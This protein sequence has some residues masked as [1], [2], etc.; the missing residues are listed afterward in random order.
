VSSPTSGITGYRFEVTKVGSSPL[1]VQ[2][3]D[4]TVQ[5]FNLTQ[6]PSFA[7]ASTYSIRVMLQKNGVWLNYY[8]TVCN[9][10]SPAVLSSTGATQ[11]TPS[12]CGITLPT[13]SSLIAT[14]SLPGAT[15][16]RFR[17]TNQ[18][19]GFQQ[20]LP[21]TLHWFAITML[22]QYNYGDTYTVEVAV[23]TTGSYS[24]YGSP[25]DVTTPPVPSLTTQCETT[26]VGKNT[27]ITTA[28][29]DRVT[30]YNFEV[31]NQTTNAVAFVSN[32]FNWFRLNMLNNYSPTTDYAVR[33][34]VLSSGI[35][36]DWGDACY[37]TSPAIART[38]ESPF[39]SNLFEV[40]TSPNPFGNHF[41]MFL[42]STSAADVAIKVYDMLG[43]IVEQR[44]VKSNEVITQEIG[45]NYSTGVYNVIVTQG[46]EVKT[47]RVIKR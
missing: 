24:G 36:S 6:L 46:E 7:Y 3:I 37:I 27:N 22:N 35:W 23:K 2:T 15:G 45:N 4:R 28:S 10:S 44:I 5:Y 31:T 20:E 14:T 40:V 42:N 12:Q 25:C 17:V 16:Y 33:V 38:I 8:G 32:N 26:I 11:V 30:S 19:T 41:E 1:E 21:R 34:Q 18:R 29:L 9:V 43:R 47:L 13:I 39:A